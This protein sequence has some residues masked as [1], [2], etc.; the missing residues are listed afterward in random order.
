MFRDT[1][2]GREGYSIIGQGRVEEIL[3]NKSDERRAAFEEAAGVMKYRVRKEE[4]QRKLEN[5]HKN[6]L[7][8]NDILHE[9]EERLEP[10]EQQSAVAREYLALR[11][12]L[13]EIEINMFLYQYDMA[14]ERTANL[15]ATMEQ[16]AS[17]LEEG[18]AKEAAAAESCVVA[19][20][21]E[22]ELENALSQLQQKLIARSAGVETRAG[23][24]N[25]AQ[26][27]IENLRRETER[28]R[29][30]ALFTGQRGRWRMR[31]RAL[32]A[33]RR[34]PTSPKHFKNAASLRKRSSPPRTRIFRRGNRPSRRPKTASSPP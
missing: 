2:I 23:E 13:K 10:L 19:E 18:T 17:E 14:Q 22:R 24:A 3:S 1:G 5:T 4:A 21:R 27:R 30:A 11:D 15:R 6:L 7:R 34:K 12:E 25:V 31:G 26:E 29:E 16:L 9:L 32:S 20:S 33:K 28:G 8:L